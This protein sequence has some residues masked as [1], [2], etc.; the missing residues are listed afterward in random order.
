M[1]EIF[2]TPPAKSAAAWRIG[3]ACIPRSP[4]LGF[5][6]GSSDSA[7][8]IYSHEVSGMASAPG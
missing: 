5:K 7:T 8:G 4:G 1:P 6:D 3:F 2:Q